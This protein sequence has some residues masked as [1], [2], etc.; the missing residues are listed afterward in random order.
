MESGGNIVQES[1][2]FWL[3]H[4]TV[5]SVGFDPCELGYLQKRLDTMSRGEL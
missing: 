4:S 1:L 2:E 3:T 5:L